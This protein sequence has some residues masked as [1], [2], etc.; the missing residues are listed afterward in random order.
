M[1]FERVWSKNGLDCV[2]FGPKLGMFCCGSENGYRFLPCW[3][4]K[5]ETLKV[6]SGFFLI[7]TD[8][9]LRSYFHGCFNVVVDHT[10]AVYSNAVNFSLKA[11]I[12]I[13]TPYVKW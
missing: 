5:G 11:I 9:K 12:F 6:K 2:H 1:L 7:G 3:L 13:Q 10:S 8:C 4:E